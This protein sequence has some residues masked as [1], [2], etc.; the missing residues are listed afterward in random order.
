MY[1]KHVYIENASHTQI[2]TSYIYR[3]YD[4]IEIYS[5]GK[6]TGKVNTRKKVHNHIYTY[7]HNTKYNVNPQYE[8]HHTHRTAPGVIIYEYT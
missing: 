2:D 6:I 7:T 4:N 8:N 5:H 1:E 3:V